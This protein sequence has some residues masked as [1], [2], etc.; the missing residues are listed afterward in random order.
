MSTVG[1]LASLAGGLFVGVGFAF[2]GLFVDGGAWQGGL[3]LLGGLGGLGGS[4][5]DSLMGAVLEARGN[6][7]YAYL[8]TSVL[9][10][11]PV[12][13]RNMLSAYA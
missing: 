4:L 1:T 5:L 8:S 10:C 7:I 12:R 13:S 9:T 11:T 2:L 6:S 3:V